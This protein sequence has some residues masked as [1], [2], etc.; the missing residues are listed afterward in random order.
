MI[1]N[2]NTPIEESMTHWNTPTCTMPN[3]ESCCYCLFPVKDSLILLL[4]NLWSGHCCTCLN[5]DAVSDC[6]LSM[7]HS[8]VFSVLTSGA[9]R[10]VLVTVKRSSP[11]LSN[12]QKKIRRRSFQELRCGLSCHVRHPAETLALTLDA[13]LFGCEAFTFHFMVYIRH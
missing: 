3:W 5:V 12:M 2:C 6:S 1:A 11:L 8:N 9:L 10:G 4:H 13:L 7:H